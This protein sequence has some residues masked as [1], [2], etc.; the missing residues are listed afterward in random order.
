MTDRTYGDLVLYRRLLAEARP[1][2]AHIGAIFVVS[3][4]STPLALLTPVPLKIAVDSVLGT[5][6][7]PGFLS[8]VLP[9]SMTDGDTRVLVLA[10]ALTVLVAV[11]AGAQDLG[12]SLLRG[13]AGERM[14]LGFRRR[15]FNHIQRLS[16][17]YHDEKGTADATYR[18]QYDAP[19]IQYVAIDGVI[20]LVSAT[21]TLVAMLYVV[22][23]LDWQLALVAIAV[24]PLLF[25]ASR[26]YRA[27]LR[28][29]SREVKRLES[30]AVGVVQEVLGA[31]RVVKAFGQEERESERFSS[32]ANEG[33]TAR[34]RL[35]LVEGSLGL[36][37]GSITAAGTATVLF[38][39]VRH[40][41]SGSLTLGELLLAMSYLSQLYAPLR[42][43]SRKV[44]SLQSHLAGAERAFS[45][46]DEPTDVAESPNPVQLARARGDISFRSVGFR[47]GSRGTEDRYDTEFAA[48]SS[49]TL[50]DVSFD[51][52]A[53]SR[54][55]ITGATGAGKS[56]LVSLLSRFYDPVE[57][58]I[59]LDGVDL[60]DYRLSDLRSQ[61]SIVLQE[62]VLFS[63]SI[64]ENIAYA[65][66]S[67]TFSEIAAAAQAA[68]IHDFIAQLPD[69]Y[70][71]L[72]GERGMRLSGGERQ[73]ISL[74]RAFL[75]NAPLLILDEP[76]SSVDVVTEARIIEAMERL[77]E[78]RTTF[79]ISHRESA[80]RSCDVLI[81]V[82]QGSSAVVLDARAESS[83]G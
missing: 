51:V 75:K 73:R 2:W 55:G 9:S 10:A 42:T 56:T 3:L 66:P 68:N 67:A 17:A 24:S 18:I 46:L 39:G 33:V 65:R 14:V 47:Y 30:S 19:S 4:L 45:I 71:T 52:P 11:L 23:V 34:I 80:L 20:P 70:Q 21:V 44:A 54:V 82:D 38:V 77:M 61:F 83:R 63:T 50:R 41:Q 36:L 48:D 59:L 53:G 12:S 5:D 72:V 64:L 27:R 57:G 13:Y 58:Q 32:R 76:T 43:M 15:L 16:L 40:V 7:V 78:G 29:R 35:T 79:L 22:T 60:R 28:T 1:Y 49:W 6:P 37:I 8:A 25:T 69:G 74:A 31:L 26:V 62:P 81:R